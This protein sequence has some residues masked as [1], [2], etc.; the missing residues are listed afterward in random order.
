VVWKKHLH[1]DRQELLVPS[2]YL[3]RL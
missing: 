1:R 2:V 3:D